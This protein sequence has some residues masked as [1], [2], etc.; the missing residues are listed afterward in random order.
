MSIPDLTAVRVAESALDV[1]VRVA[2]GDAFA[3][4]ERFFAAADTKLELGH[5]ARQIHRQRHHRV[6]PLV[7]GFRQ[8]TDLAAMQE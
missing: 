3:L 5:T 8:F 6:A 7:G 2:F 4:V 1:A